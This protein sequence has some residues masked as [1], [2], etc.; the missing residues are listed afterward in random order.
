MS[1]MVLVPCIKYGNSIIN[2]AFRKIMK[3][4][5]NSLKSK[6]IKRYGL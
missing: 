1:F 4:G 5:K 3:G 2:L 6:L